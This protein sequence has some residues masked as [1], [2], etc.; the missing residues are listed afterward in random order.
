MVKLTTDL[1]PKPKVNGRAW[2]ANQKKKLPPCSQVIIFKNLPPR[3]YVMIFKRFVAKV[4]SSLVCLFVFLYF[5]HTIELKWCVQSHLSSVPCFK[6]K[7]IKTK[8]LHL[9]PTNL[10]HYQ[11]ITYPLILVSIYGTGEKDNAWIY[12]Q[13]SSEGIKKL[14][15]WKINKKKRK[16]KVIA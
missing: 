7:S 1:I 6:S 11:L 15:S 13:S 12:K 10:F 14:R 3:S 9:S 16:K 8:Y 2:R 5:L 4:W